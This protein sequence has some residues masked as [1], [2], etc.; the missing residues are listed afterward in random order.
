M[1]G[2]GR[3]STEAPKRVKYSLICT[4]NVFVLFL[5]FTIKYLDRFFKISF[6]DLVDIFVYICT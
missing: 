2:M 3:K 5:T 1:G 6:F 4:Y